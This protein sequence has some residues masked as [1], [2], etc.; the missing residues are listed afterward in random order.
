MYDIFG[1]KSSRAGPLSGALT[2]WSPP[3]SA[4]HQKLTVEF[5][6]GQTKLTRSQTIIKAGSRSHKRPAPSTPPSPRVSC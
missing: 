5:R 2:H 1:G 6:T 3:L 4:T